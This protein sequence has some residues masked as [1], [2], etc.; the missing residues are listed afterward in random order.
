MSSL[1]PESWSTYLP[2]DTLKKKKKVRLLRCLLNC[3]I[4]TIEYFIMLMDIKDNLEFTLAPKNSGQ[5][6]TELSS[7]STTLSFISANHCRLLITINASPRLAKRMVRLYM[8]LYKLGLHFT[9]YLLTSCIHIHQY[10]YI[11]AVPVIRR[12][13]ITTGRSITIF[14]QQNLRV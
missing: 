4:R 6:F 9:Y 1:G 12:A 14:I 8:H 7:R 10:F 5:Q 13:E 3:R 11:K 2:C